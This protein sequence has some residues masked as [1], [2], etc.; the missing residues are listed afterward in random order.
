MKRNK[1]NIVLLSLVIS[2]GLF[3]LCSCEADDPYWSDD[4]AGRW[5]LSG[6]WQCM[7]YPDETLC[8]FMDGTGHWEDNYSGDYED[9]YYYCDG[10]YLWFQWFPANGPSYTEDC[11][12]YMTNNNAIQITYPPTAYDGPTT[13]YY[14]RIN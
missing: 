9:F 3:G 4:T 5:Y 1:L 7:Q 12:I 11:S 6:T 13:L 10:N 2:I 14:T 8:F